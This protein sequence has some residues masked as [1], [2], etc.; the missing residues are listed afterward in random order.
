MSQTKRNSTR[1]PRAPARRSAPPPG[2]PCRSQFEGSRVRA[3]S[4][5]R[6]A[7]R[8]PDRRWPPPRPPDPLPS[9]PLP[10]HPPRH[11]PPPAAPGGAAEPDTL[12]RLT[13]L[14]GSAS[15]SAT[16]YGRVQSHPLRPQSLAHTD[17]G[18]HP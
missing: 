16:S 7:E 8:P 4:D 12:E 10:A 17:S 5:V 14:S 13:P 11:P 6:S 2:G 9:A 1:C 15:S 3:R 18:Q